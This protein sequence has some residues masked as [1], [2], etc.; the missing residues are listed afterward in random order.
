[1]RRYA[2]LTSHLRTLGARAIGASVRGEPLVV[3]ERGTGSRVAIVVAGLHA[4]EWIGVH[5]ALAIVERCVRRGDLDADRRVIIAPCANPDGYRAVSDDL[6][7][8]RRRF[9]RGNANAVDLNR[10]FPTDWQRSIAPALPS[11]LTNG[12]G[13]GSEPEVRAIC[14]LLDAEVAAGRTIE[15]AISLHSFGRKLLI[16]PGAHFRRAARDREL[17]TVA[18]LVRARLPGYTIDQVARWLPGAFAHGLEIDHFHARYG[19]RALLVECSRGGFSLARPRTW[20]APH[21]WYNPP[22]ADAQAREIAAALEPLVMGR[23]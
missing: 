6:A 11:L 13:P 21:A 22:D 10:N 15:T 5:A 19:A 18:A 17:R 12:A 1:M 20:F 16:P 7:A 3:V 14:D 8:G 23:V 2:E 9:R 4:L